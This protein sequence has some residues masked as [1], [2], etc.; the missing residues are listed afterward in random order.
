MSGGKNQRALL[1]EILIAA[2]FF[3]LSASVLLQVFTTAREYS[4]R[5]GLQSEALLQAQS[6]VGRLYAQE[7]EAAALKALGYEEND[8]VWTWQEEDYCL[9]VSLDREEMPSGMLHTLLVR[10]L[11]SDKVIAELPAAR[12]V[13]GEV[14]L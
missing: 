13:P 11:S 12:Y 8:G 10:V 1:M 2:L 5:A 3:S 7:D 14:G 9:T 4:R 6:L